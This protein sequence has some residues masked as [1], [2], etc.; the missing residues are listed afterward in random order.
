MRRDRP[1]LLLRVD[2]EEI[3]LAILLASSA[4]DEER[5]RVAMTRPATRQR[6]LAAV[7]AALDDLAAG[8]RAA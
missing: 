6:I 5:I 4:E 3:P 7:A 1:A 8:R 2:L